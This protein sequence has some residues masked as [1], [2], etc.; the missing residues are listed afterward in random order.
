MLEREPRIYRTV[1]LPILAAGE[2]FGGAVGFDSAASFPSAAR[3]GSRRG[4]WGNRSSSMA[5][6][7]AAVT[8]ASSSSVRLIVGTR[9]IVSA[10]ICPG[11]YCDASR[12]LTSAAVKVR[13]VTS[14][15]A[16][17]STCGHSASISSRATTVSQSR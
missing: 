7:I 4:A 15:W 8:A 13:C 3:S 14:A 1:R 16:T 5:R 9:R 17:F 2:A 12:V 11:S 6:R 10:D